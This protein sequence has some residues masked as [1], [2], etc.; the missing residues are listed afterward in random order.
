VAHLRRG[1]TARLAPCG[2][3]RLVQPPLRG[4]FHRNAVS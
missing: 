3:I 2:G 1:A 4:D